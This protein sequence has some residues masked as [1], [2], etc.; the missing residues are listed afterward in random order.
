MNSAWTDDRNAREELSPAERAWLVR[1]CARL[2]GDAQTAEDL[3]QET[4]LVAWRQESALRDPARRAAW[5]A[6]I[7]HNMSRHWYRR[8]ARE[9]THVAPTRTLFGID[10]F[11]S[12]TQYADDWDIEAVLERRELVDLLDRALALLPA[13]TREVLI[14]RYVNEW[15]HAEIADRL[16]VS[17][18][19]VW[20]RVHRGKLLL[21]RALTDDLRSEAVAHGLV[22]PEADDWR[23]TR[24]WCPACGE[25]RLVGRFAD[26]N[27]LQ[28]DCIGC[29][30]IAPLGL[31]RSTVLRTRG[32]EFYGGVRATELLRGV[33]GFKP[34]YNR[35]HAWLHETFRDGFAERTAICLWCGGAA[36]L[37]TGREAFLGLH[38][39]QA[40][41]R[42]CG[43]VSEIGAVTARAV[44]TPEGRAFW[45][46]HPRIRVLPDREVEVAGSPAI[47]A[48]VESVT[49]AARLDVLFVRDTLQI[50]G[51]HGAPE[52]SVT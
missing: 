19:A 27:D 6:G 20:M 33:K 52:Q 11:E 30:L 45:R 35:V 47:V 5:L 17:E 21:K 40:V 51:V 37:R 26:G 13:E 38:Q 23:E 2:T 28:L 42:Q 36:S 43:Q 10:G 32:I 9:R 25:R 41:C 1:L 39:I 34:A 18:Q 50:I 7:A 14:R 15:P 4:L 46:E 16:G 12:D 8:Q 3:A 48:G 24:I 22:A 49:T 44:A 29:R 31:A